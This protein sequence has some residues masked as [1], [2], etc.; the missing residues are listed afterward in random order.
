MSSQITTKPTAGSETSYNNSVNIKAVFALLTLSDGIPVNSGSPHKRPVKWSVLPNHGVT[1]SLV[2]IYILSKS[3]QWLIKNNPVDIWSVLCVQLIFWAK[4]FPW[5][6]EIILL[7]IF[8]SLMPWNE[9]RRTETIFHAC[10]RYY[11]SLCCTATQLQPTVSALP[12][13]Q[14]HQVSLEETSDTVPRR[15]DV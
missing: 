6:Y 2:V 10:L 4:P 11:Y 14:K 13:S 8:H 3:T 7:N 5:F 12:E 1:I 15:I 9:Q